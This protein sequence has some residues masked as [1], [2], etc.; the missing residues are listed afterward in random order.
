MKIKYKYSQVISFILCLALLTTGITF[1]RYATTFTLTTPENN[2][3]QVQAPTA[4]SETYVPGTEI[5]FPGEIPTV[6]NGGINSEEVI[7]FDYDNATYQ[8]IGVDDLLDPNYVFPT[9]YS[10]YIPASAG[11]ENQ[12]LVVDKWSENINWD[13]SGHLVIEPDIEINNWKNVTLLSKNG[14]IIIND[15]IIAGS[16]KPYEVNITAENGYIEANGTKIVS[17]SG[18]EKINLVAKKDI[19]ISDAIF[20]SAGNCGINIESTA[21]DINAGGANIKA[22]G[23][24]GTAIIKMKS[25]GF[26]DLNVANLV[27]QVE[28]NISGVEGISAKS[29]KIRNTQYGGHNIY[30]NSSNGSIDLSSLESQTQTEVISNGGNVYIN[31]NGDISIT[32]AKIEANGNI[33]LRATD[34]GVLYIQGAIIKAING[35]VNAYNLTVEGTANELSE[36]NNI[37]EPPLENNLLEVTEMMALALIQE[38]LLE[39]ELLEALEDEIPAEVV[40]EE[41]PEKVIEEPPEVVEEEIPEKESEEPPEVVEEETPEKES[42]EPSEVV[43]EEIPEKVI[44]EPPE[45]VEEEI[46][47]K[48]IEEPPEVVEEEPPEVVEEEPPEVVEE[49]IPEKVI[50]EPPETVVEEPPEKVVEK[51]TEEVPGRTPE[52]AIEETSKEIVYKV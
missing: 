15:I 1:S 8:A 33:E 49:E 50:E 14:D 25:A 42:E 45:V 34:V 6:S 11:G 35:T 18:N 19:N 13:I 12:T 51:P 36:P 52:K 3:V 27:S 40:E 30:I 10:L 39:E 4:S 47:E 32:S 43:E 22:T 24:A 44:K 7:I 28:V 38:K 46:P 37:V 31:A 20:E 21:G 17:G 41:I 48:V 9:G 29:A 2:T 5:P 26:I 23:G 16:L